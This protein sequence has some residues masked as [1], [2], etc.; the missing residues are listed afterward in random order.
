[1]AEFQIGG[2]IIRTGDRPFVIAEAGVNHEGDLAMA[3]R[4][5]AQ[6]A[7]AGAD[8][9]KFQ[10]YKADK[11]AAVDSPAY[12]Q[13]SSTQ[14]EYFRRY[15]RFDEPEYRH[16]AS[17]AR[18]YGIAFISTPFDLEA[19]DF[20]EPLVAVYKV[21]SADITHVQLLRYIA[22]KKK[23][24]ILSTG[25]STLAEI[26]TAVDVLKEN[27]A[28][29]V[30][31]LHCILHY[32]TD[33]A[34][35]NLRFIAYLAKVFPDCVVGYSDHTRPDQGMALL[36]A[37]ALS[38]AS[39]IEK[40]FTL[41]KTLP[42]NDHYHAMNPGD[43]KLLTDNLR[44]VWD[45]LGSEQR[46]L[47]PAELLARARARRSLVARSFI[48]KGTRITAEELIAKRPGS[49]IPANQIDQV[50]GRMAALDIPADTILEWSML[51]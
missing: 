33:Y 25:A 17:V 45:A 24:V 11:L 31:L 43:L 49:G 36:T 51:I 18:R 5:I 10:T 15:D 42:G 1:M 16:L 40:H 28:P 26:A 13:E 39:I 30:A 32:P 27:G 4:L 6:A 9:I 44:I 2:R 7:E 22:R 20:L 29:Q 34:E 8:A 14:R 35:A 19:V 3:E 37:A 50:V 38:G 48:G 23:P 21:A 12:W 47:L 46:E 41:D